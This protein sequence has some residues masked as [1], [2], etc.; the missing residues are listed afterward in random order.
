MIM[1]IYVVISPQIRE[2]DKP[3]SASQK[4]REFGPIESLT[5]GGSK[6]FDS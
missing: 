3:T 6:N 5:I 2:I 1:I 4:K